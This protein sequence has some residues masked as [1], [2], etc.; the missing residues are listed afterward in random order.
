MVKLADLIVRH[1]PL[2]GHTDVKRSSNNF[3]VRITVS[4]SISLASLCENR[5]TYI[6]LLQLNNKKH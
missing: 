4:T 1:N 2:T 6:P 3:R 5:L